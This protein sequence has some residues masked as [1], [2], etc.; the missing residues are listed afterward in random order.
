MK[1]A[2]NKKQVKTYESLSMARNI[3][4]L[5]YREAEEERNSYI[6]HISE[7]YHGYCVVGVEEII[8]K[9][10]DKIILLDLEEKKYYF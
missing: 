8:S 1:I 6:C 2:L 5:E 4:W 3:K 7:M 10:K 9:N